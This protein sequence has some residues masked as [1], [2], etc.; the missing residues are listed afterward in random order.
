[1]RTKAKESGVWLAA[2]VMMLALWL[3]AQQAQ[4]ATS[5]LSR[6]LSREAIPEI[7]DV[8]AGHPRVAG[9]YVE[10]VP[11]A[12]NGLDEALLTVLLGNLEG[13][14]GVSLGAPGF[15]RRTAASSID[16]LSCT[17]LPSSDARLLLS[18]QA[19]DGGKARVVLAL[20]DAGQQE[21]TWR[22]WQ[23]QGRLSRDESRALDERAA[24]AA[25]GTLAAPWPEDAV[26]QAA[27]ALS[28]DLACELKVQVADRVALH[29]QESAGAPAQVADVFNASRHLVGDLREV[30][31]SRRA[32]LAVATRIEPFQDNVLQLWLVGTPR[33]DG[34]APVQAVTYVR[35]RVPVVSGSQA[36]ARP[37]PATVSVTATP[38]PPV[39]QVTAAAER[40]VA[41]DFIDV[42]MLDVSQS[43]RP[44]SAADLEVRI[45]LVNRG[46]WPIQ[47]A[48][49]ISGGHYLNCVP[50]PAYYRHDRYGYLEGEIP[51]G[52]SLLR[53]L[54]VSGVSHNPNPW[55][56]PRKCAGFKDLEGFE[57]FDGKGYK[58]TEFVRWRM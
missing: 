3:M 1:M 51:P 54:A 18:T 34:F 28:T 44:F 10:L 50:E 52:Q 17:P 55:F 30:E 19:L 45:Q 24:V 6:W 20:A 5:P 36:V 35:G 26:Q 13:R 14:Q 48:F 53:S 49:S 8:L 11:L 40:G 2:L 38:M 46:Q 56:G 58:V 4:A 47:Y 43:D 42:S 32:D 37:V 31:L 21:A 12:G 9:Q 22:R 16:D 57:N 15:A 29:W 33:G 39:R 23:W 7:G 41:R 27:M 25:D